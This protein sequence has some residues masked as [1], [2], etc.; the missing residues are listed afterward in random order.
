M[1]KKSKAWGPILG[2][3]GRRHKIAAGFE[4]AGDMSLA[5]SIQK[6]KE[7]NKCLTDGNIKFAPVLY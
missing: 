7:N 2:D 4:P 3:P 5:A 6:K 1:V